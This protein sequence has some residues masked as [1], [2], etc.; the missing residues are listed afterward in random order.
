AV[1]AVSD[2]AALLLRSTD[3]LRFLPAANFHGQATATFRAWDQTAGAFGKLSDTSINGG[4]SAFSTATR[5]FT[6]D[7]T[8]VNDAPA[9]RSDYAKGKIHLPSG[10]VG[11][12]SPAGVKVGDLA[13]A[14][15]VDVDGDGL[16]IAVS[17]LTRTTKGQWQYSLNGT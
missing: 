13:A 15:V 6:V 16:G 7:V 2:S 12:T 17:G 11:A 9:A 5:T 8:P 3:K 4:S 14:G 1:G 10:A